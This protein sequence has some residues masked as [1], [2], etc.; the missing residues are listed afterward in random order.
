MKK[1]PILLTLFLLLLSGC[2]KPQNS[3]ATPVQLPP[4]AKVK[5]AQPLNQKITEWDEFTGRIEAVNT[6]E[7]RA[8]V[9][10]YLEK[11]NF[12]AGAT[13]KKGDL[14]F[15]IDSKPFKAQLSYATAELEQAKSKQELAR[16]ELARAENLLKAK[17]ISIEEYDARNKGLR[18]AAAAVDASTAQVASAKL[19]LEFTEVRAPIN[20]RI[21]RELITAGNLVN[22]SGGDATKLATIVST[23]PVYVTV[24]IDERAILNY[25][26]E[27]QK[28][29]RNLEGTKVELALS[30]EQ[31][32][33]HSG[34]VDYVAPTENPVTGTVSLR[35][36]FTNADELLSPGFFARMRLRGGAPYEGLL[37]PDR[38]IGSD[39][40]NRI[41]WV[42]DSDKKVTQ[43]KIIVGK[44]M[45]D[46][47][48]ISEGLKADEWVVIEGL[49]KLRPDSVVEPE[50]ITLFQ[51]TE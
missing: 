34:H 50:K 32:F 12:N 40:A 48:V 45:G 28:Q 30:D 5:I 1:F 21:S 9:S 39:Q 19:N 2:D 46:L 14:L 26:R 22:G 42:M 35:G 7:V 23:N 24:D 4:P 20:G 44:K 47:R 15:V 16:N 36:V 18:G 6:V 3:S 43:R 10:G 33:P 37:L 31:G 8:R 13:V 41:I 17:A 25:R 51:T 11:V 29:G 38:A 27:A 49:Q